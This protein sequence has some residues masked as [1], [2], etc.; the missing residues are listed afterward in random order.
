[1]ANAFRL[2]LGARDEAVKPAI[3]QRAEAVGE[4]EFARAVIW[5]MVDAKFG[6]KGASPE[7]PG[8]FTTTGEVR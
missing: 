2:A 8:N 4:S 3:L 6:S 1:M 5:L 7:F